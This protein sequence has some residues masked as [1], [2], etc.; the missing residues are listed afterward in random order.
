[1][2]LGKGESSWGPFLKGPPSFPAAAASLGWAP[3]SRCYDDRKRR[4]RRAMLVERWRLVGWGGGF[5]FGDGGGSGGWGRGAGRGQGEPS[6]SDLLRSS[7]PAPF[8]PAC[9][10][11]LFRLYLCLP[12]SLD[13]CPSPSL[14]PSVSLSLG[15]SLPLLHLPFCPPG[16]FCHSAPAR[17]NFFRV[18]SLSSL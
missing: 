10:G 6:L 9:F 18:L 11:C 7:E 4:W 2:G 5:L 13:L 17:L 15:L 8:P 1:M 16:T 3:G 14:S 12:R